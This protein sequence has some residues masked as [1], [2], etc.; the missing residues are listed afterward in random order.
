MF[1]LYGSLGENPVNAWLDPAPACGWQPRP[2]R[3]PSGW[4]DEKRATFQPVDT[5]GYGELATEF[6]G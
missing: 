4:F 6:N 3:V 1:T 5:T 2:G